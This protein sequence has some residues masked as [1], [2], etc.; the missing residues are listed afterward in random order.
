MTFHQ[1]YLGGKRKTSLCSVKFTWWHCLSNWNPAKKTKRNI[2]SWLAVLFVF[3]QPPEKKKSL[4]FL[5]F[6]ASRPKSWMLKVCVSLYHSLN[7]YESSEENLGP[8]TAI[9]IVPLSLSLSL[10]YSGYRRRQQHRSTRS[11][12]FCYCQ[13]YRTYPLRL[14]RDT[15]CETNPS[16]F[17]H[18]NTFGFCESRWEHY[19]RNNIIK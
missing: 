2:N 7:Q 16:A 15:K 8:Y 3:F 1:N 14:L 5:Y 6:L 4:P 12:H 10:F 13:S 9:H 17:L 18:N 11:F 19:R